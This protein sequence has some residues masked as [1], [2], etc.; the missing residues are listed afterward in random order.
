MRRGR[1]CARRD[2]PVGRL[3]PWLLVTLFKNKYRIE[4]ARL[5]HWD[6]ASAGWYFITICARGKECFFGEIV[7]GEMELSPIG[8]I[9]AE[10]WLKTP[11]I[12]AT[13]ELDEWV[14]MPNHVHGILVIKDKEETP[15]LRLDRGVS[16]GP[17]LNAGSVGA[18]IGQFKSVCTKRIWA[19]GQL[20]FAWHPRFHD[21]IIRD[22]AEL[23]NKRRYIVEN[24]LRWEL[25]EYNPDLK[26]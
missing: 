7:D 10:E 13:V 18:V 20:G 19:I 26:S 21:R 23:L 1:W 24:P 6:Y 16:T 2:G 14:V 12:R 22:E 5:K 17:R 11:M 15:P 9:V 8:E 25:D 4:S 3:L